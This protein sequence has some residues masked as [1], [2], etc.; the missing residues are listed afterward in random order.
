M[1]IIKKY[2][3]EFIAKYTVLFFILIVAL[4]ILIG[5]IAFYNIEE[6]TFFN[7]L[8]FTSVTMSTIGY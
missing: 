5:T 3:N 7:S 2:L 8:Y 1:H 4:V 6:R